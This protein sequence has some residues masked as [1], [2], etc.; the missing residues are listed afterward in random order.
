MGP[1]PRAPELWWEGLVASLT[2]LLWVHVGET[3]MQRGEVT[4]QAT[5]DPQCWKQK[6]SSFLLGLSQP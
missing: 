2:H 4:A 6:N 1:Q 5:T 3:G